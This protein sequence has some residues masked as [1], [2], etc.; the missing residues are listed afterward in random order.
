VVA[1]QLT[2]VSKQYENAQPALA[3]ISLAVREGAF[4]CVM[5]PS[6]CGKSTLLHIV[7]GLD[8]P[9][10]GSVVVDGTELTKLTEAPLARF[11][12]HRV[13]FIFQFFNLLDNLSAVDNVSLPAKLAGVRRGTAEASANRLLLRLGLSGKERSYPSALSGGERQRVA[14]ARALVNQPAL[15]LADEPTGALDSSSGARVMQILTQLNLAG[16]TIVMVTHDEQLA[17]AY[18]DHIVRLQ[19][20]TVL[21]ELRAGEAPAREP[22]PPA[23]AEL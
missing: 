4:T 1:I 5:G 14:I 15:L 16:Q 19:D 8:R 11:R 13:G 3:N 23:R 17:D 7:G 2:G 20:G 21:G 12:L 6:G 9:S 18:A 22:A 10:Q